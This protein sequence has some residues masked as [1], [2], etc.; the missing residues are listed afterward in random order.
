VIKN[1]LCET[2]GQEMTSIAFEGVLRY[3]CRYCE[4]AYGNDSE[5]RDGFEYEYDDDNWQQESDC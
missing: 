3:F 5:D 2:C 1:P 4:M